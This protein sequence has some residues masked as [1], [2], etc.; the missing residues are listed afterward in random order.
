MRPLFIR[1]FLNPAVIPLYFPA[2]NPREL[3]GVEAGE[4][5]IRCAE[6]F[7]EGIREAFG[8][9]VRVHVDY[10]RAEAVGGDPFGDGLRFFERRRIADRDVP[11]AVG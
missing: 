11:V 4:L 3:V 5:I 8:E 1:T 2:D 10:D 6:L 9:C 7:R